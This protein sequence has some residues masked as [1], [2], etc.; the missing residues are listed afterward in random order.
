MRSKEMRRLSESARGPTLAERQAQLAIALAAQAGPPPGFD[1]VR[2]SRA[3][4]ALADKR[5]AAAAKLLPA[6]WRSL[7]P[8]AGRAFRAYVTAHP[9]PGDHV[10]DALA[11]GAAVCSRRSP[12][13]AVQDVLLLRVRSGWPLRVGRAHR[14][15]FVAARI[16][17]R[18][19][20]VALLWR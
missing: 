10:T 16:A 2:V 3:S 12:P 15:L 11:F 4:A 1:E 20:S 9:F 8:E 14:R 5:A 17:G 13:A 6:L 7:G 19:R 18:P